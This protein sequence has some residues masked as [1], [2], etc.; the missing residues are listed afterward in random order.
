MKENVIK[1]MSFVFA[2]EIVKL[3]K[4]LCEEKK[5]IYSF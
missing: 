3:Y 2:V 1:N 4:Y 5:G